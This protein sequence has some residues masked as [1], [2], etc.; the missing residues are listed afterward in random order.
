[1]RLDLKSRA[2]LQ[3]VHEEGIAFRAIVDP[4]PLTFDAQATV[5][6]VSVTL[7]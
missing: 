4:R 7:H 5:I 3:D 2:A 1:M 6:A